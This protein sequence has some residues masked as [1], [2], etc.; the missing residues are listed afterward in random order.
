[1][2]AVLVEVGFITNAEDERFMMSSA[3]QDKLVKS[4]F[5]GFKRYKERVE[6]KAVIPQKQLG[7]SE[8]K[9]AA[10][11]TPERHTET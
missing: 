4:I 10:T 7:G 9:G 6:A 11:P 2:P 1:M 5:A 8:E 3:G